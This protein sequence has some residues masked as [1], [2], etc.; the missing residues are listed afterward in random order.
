MGS[1]RRSVRE[2]SDCST[3]IVES[4][5][6]SPTSCS[7]SEVPPALRSALRLGRF[8]AL[9]DPG[10]GVQGT[11]AGDM[12]RTFGVGDDGPSFGQ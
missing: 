3:P 8:T 7:R 1:N 6:D 4:E 9:S 10:G 11:V 2:M 5:R 12:L